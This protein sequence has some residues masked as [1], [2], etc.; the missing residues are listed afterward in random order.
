MKRRPLGFLF[1]VCL[2]KRSRLL[3]CELQARIDIVFFPTSLLRGTDL[4]S[5]NFLVMA[6]PTLEKAAVAFWPAWDSVS[7]VLL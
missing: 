3:A 2:Q 5:S 1:A 4:T 6:E 7:E